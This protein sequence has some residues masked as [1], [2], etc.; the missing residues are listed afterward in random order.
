MIGRGSRRLPSKNEFKIIDLGN[1][2]RR[3][4]HWQDYINW[5][6]AFR[7][8]EKFLESRVSE[9]EDIQF[10]I[11]YEFPR[12][13][14]EILNT[15]K[16]LS[17]SIADAY[18]YAMD[19]GLKGRVSIEE[20]MENHAEVIMEATTDLE[21]AIKLIQLLQDHIEHRLKHYTKC[22][23]KCTPNYLKYLIETYNR[24]L[25]QKLRIDLD[26]E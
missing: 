5:Q 12:H 1:N 26:S 20:S 3:F 10:E 15:E 14:S 6:D 16:L 18:Y 7:F 19:N 4:G 9:L 8:P 21:E 25:I 2:V 13:F 22:I 23:S 17:F 24:Q 11:E